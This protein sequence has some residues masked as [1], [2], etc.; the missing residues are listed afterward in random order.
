MS[1]LSDFRGHMAS[2]G[3]LLPEAFVNPQNAAEQ[4]AE[5]HDLA[6]IAALARSLD[7]EVDP[8]STE[9]VFAVLDDAFQ[10]S[11]GGVFSFEE[12]LGYYKSARA[13]RLTALAPSE[14][15]M[16][17]LHTMDGVDMAARDR[18]EA[19]RYDVG[20]GILDGELSEDLQAKL[21]EL[22]EAAIQ[23]ARAQRPE[24][25]GTKKSDHEE[26]FPIG[27]PPTEREPDMSL[28]PD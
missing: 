24:R 3:L 23:S 15:P 4:D 8:H 25:V 27:L 21:A 18:A 6:A 9:A 2:T 26:P 17:P 5:L 11:A 19:A 28:L 7:P 22:V 20:D 16:P 1:A 14:F 10:L 12:I 13:A